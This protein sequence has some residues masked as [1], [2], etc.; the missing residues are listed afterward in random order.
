MAFRSAIICHQ[1]WENIEC[2][3]DNH[4]PLVVLG[5][6]AADHQTRPVGDWRETRAVGDH[7]PDVETDLPDWLPCTEG[8]TGSS[9]SSTVVSPGDVEIPSQSLPSFRAFSSKTFFE[10]S[11][12][13]HNSSTHIPKD[14]NCEVCRHTKVTRAP[15]R[16]NPD[17]RRYRIKIA[18]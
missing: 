16:R 6:Q 2:N 9:S 8:L 18:E 10:H 5:V 3:T 15:C 14:S 17:N 13:M 11:R 7:K 1:A 12:T 4:V